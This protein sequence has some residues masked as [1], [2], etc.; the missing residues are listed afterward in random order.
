MVKGLTIIETNNLGNF[1]IIYVY[2]LWTYMYIHICVFSY[3][4]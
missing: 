3:S 4:I 1:N 2:D